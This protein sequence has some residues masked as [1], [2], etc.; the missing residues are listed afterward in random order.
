MLEIPF[1]SVPAVGVFF[2]GKNKVVKII[3]SSSEVVLRTTKHTMIYPGLGPS[4]EVIAIC[5]VVSY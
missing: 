5:P 2:T 3:S 1:P 4:L